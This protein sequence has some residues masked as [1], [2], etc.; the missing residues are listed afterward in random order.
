MKHCIK[1]KFFFVITFVQLCIIPKLKWSILANYLLVFFNKVVHKKFF[2]S[3][4]SVFPFFFS[5]LCFV[6]LGRW[7]LICSIWFLKTRTWINQITILSLQALATYSV[8]KWSMASSSRAPKLW[9]PRI[10]CDWQA[11]LL[12]VNLCHTWK[13]LSP[14]ASSSPLS[15]L[16]SSDRI[17]SNFEHDTRK[18]STV[19]FSSPSQW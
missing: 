17:S 15:W 7:I 14:I 8:R 2:V 4:V 12:A 6:W 11:G 1:C 13:P 18:C 9:A 3:F 10:I 5:F 16:R 19:M